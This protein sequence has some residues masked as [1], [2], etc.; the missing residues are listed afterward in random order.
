MKITVSQQHINDGVRCDSGACPVANA[1]H[2]VIHNKDIAVARTFVIIND[3][4]IDLPSKV[5][6]FIKSFDNPDQDPKWL[7]PFSFELDYEPEA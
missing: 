2:D 4:Q 1:L 6:D 5:E 7:E 3:E